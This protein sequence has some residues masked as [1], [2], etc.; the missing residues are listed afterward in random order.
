MKSS[1]NQQIPHPI[2]Q[3]VAFDGDPRREALARVLDLGVAEA[4][5]LR[6]HAVRRDQQR[7]VPLLAVVPRQVLEEVGHVTAQLR[8]AAV[9]GGE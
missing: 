5:Q 1:K 2:V 4:D 6:V 9:Q 3:R 8:V 7:V